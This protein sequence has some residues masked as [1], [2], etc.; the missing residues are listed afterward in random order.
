MTS[1]LALPNE[2]LLLVASHLASPKDI[3]SL[4]LS[5]R[6]LYAL[7]HSH[8]YELGVADIA[9]RPDLPTCPLTWAIKNDR[10]STLQLFLKHGAEH[11]HTFHDTE[12]TMQ[13]FSTRGENLTLLLGA[14]VLDRTAMVHLLLTHDANVNYSVRG[15]TALHVAA[16]C[17][18]VG[19]LRMLLEYGADLEA[20]IFLVG[21]TPL[22]FACKQ[23]KVGFGRGEGA[24]ERK[25]ECLRILLAAGAQVDGKDSMSRRTPLTRA[26]M[27]GYLGPMKVLLDGGADVDAK[28]RNGSTVLHSAALVGRADLV[29][30]LVERGANRGAVAVS[31]GNP[32]WE[33][34]PLEWFEQLVVYRLGRKGGVV[35]PDREEIVGL[36]GGT[37]GR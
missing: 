2:L 26:V 29:R 14:V 4:I 19:T 32:R 20:R 5:N 8:L 22:N 21:Q 33:G 34:T 18:Y 36:L 24:E 25:L 12:C 11:D 31:E 23:D 30:V 28:D 6:R 35:F 15:K 7:F 10:F 13:F 9:S 1:L 16:R 3:Y 17:G 27:E 37:G